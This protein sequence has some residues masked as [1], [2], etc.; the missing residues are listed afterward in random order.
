MTPWAAGDRADPRSVSRD[1]EAIALVVRF[2]PGDEGEDAVDT[3]ADMLRD[4]DAPQVVVGGGRLMDGEMEEQAA[5]DL[6]RAEILSM[7]VVAVLLFVIFGGLVAAGLPVLI[8]LVGAAATF[9][10][11]LLVSIGTDVSVYAINIVTMLGLGLAVDYALLI[12]ARFREERAAG[13][14][15]ADAIART[16]ATAGRTVAFS[17]WPCPSARCSP[18]RTRSCVPWA[19]PGS[20]WS[21]STWWLPSRSCRRFWPSSVTASGLRA[22]GVRA[23]GHP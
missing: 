14:D 20:A 15:L 4:I 13:G 1:G 21:S 3:A 11:L 22:T 23:V 19:S 5:K 6:A 18:S 8:T 2:F 10:L 17:R 16:F 9:G 12:V 7:P